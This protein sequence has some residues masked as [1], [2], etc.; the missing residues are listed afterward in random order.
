[1][2]PAQAATLAT[3]L[4][5]TNHPPV[6]TSSSEAWLVPAEPAIAAGERPL[7]DG[8]AQLDAGKYT[9]AIDSFSDKRLTAAPVS[10]WAAYYTA[11]AQLR[12]G[13]P[14]DAV[15]TL[16]PLVTSPP[17]GA[18]NELAARAFADALEAA[19][20]LPRSLTTLAALAEQPTSA[21]DETLKRL[22]EVASRAGEGGQ[23]RAAWLRLYYD[24][25][26]SPYAS[27]AEPVAA[28]ARAAAGA[29]AQD[30]FNRDLARAEAL[31]GMG[32]Y[33][34]ARPAFERLLP[35]ATGDQRELVD[36]RIAECDYFAQRYLNAV[37]RL[38]PWLT[39]ASRQAEARYFTLSAQRAL[40]RTE[41]FITRTRELVSEFPESSWSED[42]L[43]SLATHYILVNDDAS[44]SE[45]FAEILRRY[46]ASRH[47]PRAAWK[48]GWWAY[49]LGNYAEAAAAFEQGAAY[50]PRADYRPSWL[51]WAGRAREALGEQDEALARYQL[52]YTDYRHTYYGRLA[53]ERLPKELQ[54]AA[55]RVVARSASDGVAPA[56]TESGL[57]VDEAAGEAAAGSA[58][59]A[60]ADE[61][62]E[63]PNGEIV[64]HLVGLQLWNEAI[65]ELQY[66]QRRWGSSS[67]VEATL[68]WIYAKQ[69]DLR[70]GINAMKRAYPQ[71]MADGGERLPREIVEVI[72]PV[73]HWDLIRKYAAERKLD[74]HMVAALIGQEST[75]DRT[76][77][78]VAN[79][80][81]LMQIL[82][83]TG[84][85]LARAEGIPRFSTSRLTDA[86]TNVRLGTRLFATLIQ[87]F[88]GA[89]FA[90]A[91]YNA[92]ESRVV[93]WKAERPGLGDEEFI[94]DIPFPETQNYVK[95]I[96]GT[97][98][99]YRALYPLTRTIDTSGVLSVPGGD[100][101]AK[102]QPAKPAAKKPPAKSPR[103]TVKKK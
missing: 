11:I 25:P 33:A 95:R 56:A 70:R 64:Q 18:V 84:R 91:S 103:Q 45:V 76:A 42:A 48:F 35:R 47:A 57:E 59:V 37:N 22:A 6:P 15:R 3:V 85:R 96:L 30:V 10:P 29:A 14:A 94:D 13:R 9:A 83:S 4:V 65:S 60:P 69:G 43:N 80:V 5:P 62:D 40:G 54:T 58:H 67:R 12:L 79:A 38:E 93:R 88:G 77:K 98:A 102:A 8:I 53:A 101:A 23:A 73:A 90:L 55:P 89:H 68:A 27:L 99:D 34:D 20:D 2:N 87:R 71:Y 78:S 21:P 36:L 63:P 74:P 50:A 17:A 41:L 24:Y 46:P 44:A 52:T 82:P 28:E 49:K 39:R 92:G 32:R 1:L 7:V 16:E 81:G 72:F 75:F 100:P 86:E 97:A 61:L 19:G 26:S 51:Y 66:A 31:F